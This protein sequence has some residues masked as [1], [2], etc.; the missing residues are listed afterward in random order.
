VAL[1]RR[2]GRAE[3]QHAEAFRFVSTAGASRVRSWMNLSPLTPFLAKT[4]SKMLEETRDQPDAL[5]QTLEGGSR[6][7][8]ELRH[9]LESGGRG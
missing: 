5:S 9:H 8:F 6:A 4:M 7:I 3:I 2:Y 1:T